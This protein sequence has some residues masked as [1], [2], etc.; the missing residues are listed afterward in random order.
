MVYDYHPSRSTDSRGEDLID[1]RED[2]DPISRFQKLQS[3]INTRAHETKEKIATLKSKKKT[4]PLSRPKDSKDSDV[5]SSS[6]TLLQLE[7]RDDFTFGGRK[8]TTRMPAS[9]VVKEDIYQP[10][11]IRET[12]PPPIQTIDFK[13]ICSSNDTATLTTNSGNTRMNGPQITNLQSSRARSVDDQKTAFETM[14]AQLDEKQLR[15]ETEIKKL[16]ETQK[17]MAHFLT[18]EAASL[19]P[20]QEVRSKNTEGGTISEQDLT[21]I[22]LSNLSTTVDKYAEHEGDD[23]QFQ[24]VA[25]ANLPYGFVFE[26]YINGEKFKFKVP[27]GGVTTGQIWKNPIVIPEHLIHVP[28]GKWKDR[29]WNISAN[30]IFH[31][32]VILSFI[33]PLC[34]FLFRLSMI[35]L[36]LDYLTKLTFDHGVVL[37]WH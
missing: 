34:K 8:R 11:D 10:S 7:S 35:T 14:M 31:P 29:L 9:V 23:S 13:T 19:P 3:S 37:Q 4:S 20:I 1:A 30:G 36:P 18:V 16:E 26:T 27:K 28:V 22:I 5:S 17:D 15:I 33:A 2:Y 6:S 24:I 21:G 32:L 12:P 25:P